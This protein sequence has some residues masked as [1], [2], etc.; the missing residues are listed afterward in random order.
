[1]ADEVVVIDGGRLIVRSDV[2]GLLSRAEKGVRVRTDQPEHL[3]D[4]LA[5]SGATS[6]LAAH[7]LLIVKGT[8]PEHVGR[9]AAAAGIPLFGLQAEE[10]NLE[11]V[12]LQLTG[13]EKQ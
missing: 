8:D 3:R 10:E 5:A 6:E 1:M 4:L 12:F 13:S 7:D 9:T 11:D 2:A